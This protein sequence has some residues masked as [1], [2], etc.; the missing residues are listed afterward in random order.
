MDPLNNSLKQQA[1]N[2]HALVSLY[3]SDVL[4]MLLEVT[5]CVLCCILII[6]VYYC[7]L[8]LYI[9]K[10]SKHNIEEIETACLP[11]Y[12]DVIKEDREELDDLPSYQDA[13]RLESEI[14]TKS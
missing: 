13:L 4:K 3:D 11:S 7:F 8:H 10:K 12:D 2:G 6:T 9:Y 1:L 14:K 5:M